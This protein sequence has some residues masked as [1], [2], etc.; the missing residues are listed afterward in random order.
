MSPNNGPKMRTPKMQNYNQTIDRYL[1]E[2][3]KIVEETP[4]GWLFMKKKI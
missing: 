2:K 4:E 3:F 1:F